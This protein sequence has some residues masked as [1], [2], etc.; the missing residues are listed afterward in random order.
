MNYDIILEKFEGPL[1][2]LYNLIE[3]E[4]IDIYDIPI[5]KIYERIGSRDCQRVFNYGYYINRN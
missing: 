2:L 1:D 4:K 5:S 3:K